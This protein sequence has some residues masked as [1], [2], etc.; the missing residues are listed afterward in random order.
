MRQNE[1]LQAQDLNQSQTNSVSIH[2]Q[3]PEQA[4]NKSLILENPETKIE[5]N[6]VKRQKSESEIKLDPST[7][8]KHLLI[9]SEDGSIKV[10]EDEGSLD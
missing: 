1:F 2:P 7:D 9:D 10:L 3:P 5:E 4:Q 6:T 8:Y